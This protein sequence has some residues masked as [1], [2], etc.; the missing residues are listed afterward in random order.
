MRISTSQLYQLGLNSILDQQVQLNKTQQQIA[1]GKRIQSP[2]ED[3]SATASSLNLNQS[4]KITEQYQRN[5]DTVRSR[6]NLEEQTMSSMSDIMNRIR[7]LAIQGNK[8]T[9][10]ETDRSA[11]AVEVR[12]NLDALLSLSN[13]R[14]SNGEY[15]FSGYQG[16]TQPFTVDASGNYIYSG[17]NGQRFVQI[18]SG[19]Q[20]ATSDSGV[21]VFQAIRNGNGTFT[22]LNNSANSGT[23]VID[24]GSVTNPS[25]YDGD[26]YNLTFPVPTSATGT[27]TFGDSIGVD[28]DLTYTLSINGTAVYTVS[29][30]GTPVNTLDDLAAEINNDTATTGVKA[31]VTGGNLSLGYTTPS[32]NPIT[33]TETLAG[34][35]D[36]DADTATG[37]FGS[38]LTGT[39]TPSNN[40]VY[41]AGD[42]TFYVVEDSLG[43]IETSGTYVD[44]AQIAFNGI[45]T[46]VAGTPQTSDAFTISPS[47]N[48]DIFTTVA[49]LV[50]ALEDN[51]GTPA[52]IASLAN[53]IGR[54]LTDTDQTMNNLDQ[55]RA[56]IGSRLNTLD[57]QQ[58]LNDSYSLQLQSTLSGLEDLDMAEAITRL[59]RQS[60]GLQ[61]AQ[62]S[63]IKIQGLSLFNYL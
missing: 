52:G 22:T 12:E 46:N 4:L 48:Q 29:E 19:R 11:I 26:T 8:S 9:L 3:P 13:T 18:G 2:S 36:G 27:L 15:L 30:S 49:N 40:V 44:G 21:D 53:A 17:D 54:V 57:E 41:N 7:E 60:V 33:V 34:A 42:A 5:I 6:Q 28:D 1:S 38:A 55:I 47:T 10:T 63:F 16:T 14:D 24:P 51:G 45:Q 31:Y 37:Y 20:I 61:A 25:A 39:T 43:N 59:E 23:G 58:N 62:Q 35:S 32:S 50:S 56:G